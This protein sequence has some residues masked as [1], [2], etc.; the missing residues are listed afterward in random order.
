MRH[1]ARAA[2]TLAGILS[3]VGSAAWAA[4]TCPTTTT[5]VTLNASAI[6]AGTSAEAAMASAI[7]GLP[8]TTS[9]QLN[10]IGTFNIKQTVAI[11][12]SCLTL[13]SAS[14]LMPAV[15]RWAG[16][17]AADKTFIF[18]DGAPQGFCPDLNPG[19]CA[20][21]HHLSVVGVGFNGAGLRLSGF[22]HKVASNTFVNTSSGLSLEFADTTTVT[23]N[24]LLGGPGISSFWLANSTISGN[25]FTNAAQPISVSG[26][27]ISNNFTNNIATGSLLWG[28]ELLGSAT[29]NISNR[30]L[31]N[32]NNRISGNRFSKP[33]LASDGN[34]GNFGGIS[35]AGGTNTTISG[36]TISC[37]GAAGVAPGAVCV[38]PEEWTHRAFAIEAAGVNST[39][40]NNTVEGYDYSI[41]V[42]ESAP[43]NPSNDTTLVQGNKLSLTNHGIAINCSS[44]ASN[45]GIDGD[46]PGCSKYVVIHKNTITEPV[47]FGIGGFYSGRGGTP[48][49]P[50]YFI[51]GVS[52][53]S[54]LTITGNNIIR[55]F[56][57]TKDTVSSGAKYGFSGINLGPIL[58]P[59]NLLISDN[60]ITMSGVPSAD[61]QASFPKATFSGIAIAPVQ[62]NHGDCVILPK[63]KNFAGSVIDH[64]TVTH[65]PTP[66]G[67]GVAAQC[68]ATK[69]L[70]VSNNTF[71]TLSNAVVDSNTD[72]LIPSGNQCINVTTSTAGCN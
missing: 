31:V 55:T 64:N 66:F 1:K 71:N 49:D 56:S 3:T 13:T 38:T 14:A 54:G 44:Q 67:A 46:S 62:M 6:P 53:L 47:A 43:G 40:T 20:W 60:T 16:A 5:T 29:E 48:Q 33:G 15:L 17:K 26:T 59:A 70:K 19:T 50:D 11:R 2:A 42:G 9:G 45:G 27:S 30:N 12:R 4:P 69:G 37:V 57:P 21:P 65:T 34:H 8:Q 41:Y 51:S 28:I 58:N 7:D 72:G 61:I 52:Q 39:V 24:T 22:G 36:N 23:G 10:L 32:V 35:V 18:D 68:G 25:K 63:T